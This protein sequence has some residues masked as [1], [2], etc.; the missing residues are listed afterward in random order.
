MITNPSKWMNYEWFFIHLAHH[1]SHSLQSQPNIGHN[2]AGNIQLHRKKLLIQRWYVP[3]VLRCILRFLHSSHWTSHWC[4]HNLLTTTFS[5]IS[6]WYSCSSRWAKN[7][8][9]KES[10]NFQLDRM[11]AT[12][13]KNLSKS[14]VIRPIVSL[15]KIIFLKFTSFP[16]YSC[17]CKHHA[18]STPHSFVCNQDMFH[19]STLL[20]PLSQLVKKH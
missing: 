12:Y 6:I 3:I 1:I 11:H 7:M 18:H 10:S 15:G 17:S 5:F 20:F 19:N 13:S 4:C 8:I 2:K 9:Q 14:K 16:F